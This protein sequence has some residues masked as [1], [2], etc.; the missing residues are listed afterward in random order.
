MDADDLP[1]MH[2]VGRFDVFAPHGM[3]PASSNSFDD[4]YI[5]SALDDQT[6]VISGQS[7][8]FKAD[9][10][11]ADQG[12]SPE[13]LL[14]RILFG[15]GCAAVATGAAALYFKSG[16]IKNWWDGKAAPTL[17]SKWRRLSGKDEP[18]VEDQSTGATAAP[19]DLSERRSAASARGKTRYKAS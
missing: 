2:Y 10:E 12:L 4:G 15:A 8:L 5:G 14:A 13:E 6:N 19:I 9:D 17:K 7:I 18:E 16:D 11:E 3:H 1:G